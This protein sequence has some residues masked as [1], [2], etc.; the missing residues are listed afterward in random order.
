MAKVQFISSAHGENRL[1]PQVQNRC[2]RLL[3]QHFLQPLEQPIYF[4][5]RFRIERKAQRAAVDL[6]GKEAALVH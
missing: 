5:A 3:S 4:S 2:S 1:T 6:I